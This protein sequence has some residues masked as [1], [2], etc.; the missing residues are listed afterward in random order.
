MISLKGRIY[1]AM[2]YRL[3]NFNPYHADIISKLKRFSQKLESDS[4]PDGF[5]RFEEETKA[6]TRYE[7]LRNAFEPSGRL[8]LYFHGGAY[9]AGLFGTYRKFAPD[10]SQAADNGETIFL[11]YR[12]APEYQYPVQLNEALDLW[13][14]L[15]QNQGYDPKNI[16]I[17]GD[18]SGG[19]LVLAL[20]LKLRDQGETLPRGA[21]CISPWADMTASGASFKENYGKDIE[22]GELGEVLTEEKRKLIHHSDIYSWLGDADRF[23]PYVSPVYAEYHDFP[24]MML[25][26]GGDEMLL[27]DTLTITRKLRQAHVPVICEIQPEMFHIYATM[28]NAFPES[29]HSYQHI[30]QFIYMLYHKPERK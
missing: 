8:L 20:L 16:I 12:T 5:I 13:K 23:D 18:S 4:C 25:T 29:A 26:A 30:M 14:D 15:I 11:D 17:G 10:F 1:R 7:R 19:N 27:S 21:F 6:G 9:I 24:P 3:S 28:G 22:F 2:M